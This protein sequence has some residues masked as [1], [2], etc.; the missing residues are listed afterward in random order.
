MSLTKM[1]KKKYGR[2]GKAC[3]NRQHQVLTWRSRGGDNSVLYQRLPKLVTV[4]QGCKRNTAKFS[5]IKQLR[6]IQ[7]NLKRLKKTQPRYVY[8]ITQ[9]GAHVRVQV[10]K[11]RMYGCSLY[12]MC[13]FSV[14]LK[15]LPNK[16]QKVNKEW[17]HSTFFCRFRKLFK[18]LAAFLLVC[19]S[20]L[21]I[22]A[23]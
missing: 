5:G 23:F 12:H 6:K 7:L 17:P 14:S 22:F 1:I 8:K 21:D 4:L 13:N 18:F 15:L 10:T 2:E 16:K 9:V 19:L 20:Q 3:V 11:Q